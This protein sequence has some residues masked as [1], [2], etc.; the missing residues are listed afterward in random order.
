VNAS[1]QLSTDLAGSEAVSVVSADWL[2]DGADVSG[3]G[4]DCGL[5]F[6][7]FGMF[8]IV[9]VNWAE[10]LN[11]PKA[12]I[13][14]IATDGI[15]I[16]FIIFSYTPRFYSAL[17]GKLIIRKAL[18]N[19]CPIEIRQSGENISPVGK[20]IE[21]EGYGVIQHLTASSRRIR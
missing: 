12:S 18:Q 5:F 1:E 19:L 14:I 20:K 8:G 3:D 2:V 15:T 7:I 17:P 21:G 16:F 13:P 10:M 9:M 11:V 4:E 6:L